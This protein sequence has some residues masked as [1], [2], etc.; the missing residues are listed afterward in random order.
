M[1]RRDARGAA[2]PGVQGLGTAGVAVS[3]V[4]GICTKYRTIKRL[5]WH[6]QSHDPVPVPCLGAGRTRNGRQRG[7]THSDAKPVGARRTRQ[8]ILDRPLAPQ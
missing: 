6:R 1:G 2:R 8:E 3:L 7:R 4:K 5:V